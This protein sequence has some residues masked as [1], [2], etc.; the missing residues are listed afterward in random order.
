MRKMHLAAQAPNEGAR[1]LARWLARRTEGRVDLAAIALRLDVVI[2]ERLI[3]GEI[4]PGDVL[5]RQLWERAGIDR[6]RFQRPAARHWFDMP[7][8]RPA[9]RAA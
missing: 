8:R 9:R 4:I 2:L 6:Y 3:A 1:L 7:A 5:G